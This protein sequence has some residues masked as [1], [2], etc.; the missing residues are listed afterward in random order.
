MPKHLDWKAKASKDHGLKFS[1][2]YSAAFLSASKTLR[3][4]FSTGNKHGF[5]S[6]P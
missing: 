6:T 4:A 5:Q 2:D 3:C 1:L